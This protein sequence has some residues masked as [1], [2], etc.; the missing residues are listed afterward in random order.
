MKKVIS[1]F[2]VLALCLTL[3]SC[4]SSNAKLEGETLELLNSAYDYCHT[5]M[6]Y[7]LRAWEFSIDHSSDS[8]KEEY[9]AL[10]G[11]F[12]ACMAMTEEDMVE[13]LIGGCGMTIED[14]SKYGSDGKTK[15]PE[16]GLNTIVNGI[17]FMD[18]SYSVAAAKYAFEQRNKAVDINAKLEQIKGNLKEIGEKSKAYELLKDY[19]LMVCEMENWVESPNGS[20]SS[21][22]SG[23]NEY[24]KSFE[25]FKQELDLV[26]G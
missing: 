16:R 20:F 26:I 9:E 12:G 8:T 11:E 24:E 19:Y 10:W 7:M 21:S 5:G 15:D 18:A 4:G 25:N 22:S 6:N 17:L 14:L 1:I 13:A 3:C 23:L 2:L